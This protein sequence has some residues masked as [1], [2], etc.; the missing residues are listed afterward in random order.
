M[1]TRFFRSKK[2]AA[3]RG[4][5]FLDFSPMAAL[6]LLL[7]NFFMVQAMW[8]KPQVMPVMVPNEPEGCWLGAPLRDNKML[9]LLCGPDK[10]FAY[11]SL[12]EPRL[13]SVDY[14]AEGLRKLILLKKQ[15]A[16]Q[17][18]GFD[19]YTDTR[20]GALKK[21]SFL[22]VVIKP[23][24]S[25]HYGNLVDVLDEMQICGLRYYSVKEP[26]PAEMTLIREPE[27]G[28]QFGDLE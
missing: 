19:E 23:L 4:A 7:V 13:D 20:T 17:Q 1:M 15:Q 2:S 11:S 14:S 12:T 21:G 16:D 18:F 3:R 10:I 22:Q 5:Q 27:K 8:K 6:G 28:W 25:A 24:P 9:T 26:L